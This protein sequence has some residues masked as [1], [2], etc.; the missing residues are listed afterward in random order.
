MIKPEIQFPFPLIRTNLSN[1]NPVYFA[2][3]MATG[4]ISLNFKLQGFDTAAKF[5]FFINLALY[6]ALTLLFVARA[7]IFKERFIDDFSDHKRAPGFFTIVAA[8]SIIGSQCHL[9]TGSIFA[10]QFFFGLS[11]TLWLISIYSIFVLLTVKSEKPVFEQAIH[12]GWLIAIVATQSIPV[13]GTSFLDTSVNNDIILFL[14]TVLWLFGGMLYI[15]IISIIFYRYMFFKFYPNDLMPPYWINMGAMAISTLAGSLLVLKSANSSLL[16]PVLPFIKGF[17][18]MF[19]ATATW[20]IPMLFILGF[21]RHAVKKIPISY[22]PLYWGLVFPLGM[23]S[24]CTI[25][26]IQIFPETIWLSGLVKVF[27]VL[28]ITAWAITFLGMLTRILSILFPTFNAETT[29]GS[30]MINIGQEFIVTGFI[31]YCLDQYMFPL[32]HLLTPLCIT[33]GTLIWITGNI[34]KM[35]LS[36]D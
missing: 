17:T 1:L 30:L 22:T 14:L 26:L 7:F 12:G 2:M 19:W 13:V 21:W 23:Y 20:W 5:L 8:N 9:M 15:W 18:L 10:A 6:V 16:L 28:G 24:V 36:C 3:V 27:T 35:T 34:R 31:I 25:R 4:I 32:P 11:L 29:R 33:I